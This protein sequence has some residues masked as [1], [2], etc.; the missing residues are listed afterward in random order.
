MIT[1]ATWPNFVEGSWE[2]AHPPAWW[3]FQ[4]FAYVGLLLSAAP[5]YVAYRLDPFLQ[6]HPQLREPM[7][8]LLLLAQIGGLC[9][10]VWRIAR[11][12]GRNA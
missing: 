5:S 4:I 6:A 11:R 7:I 8:A 9:Y 2:L 10:V 12:V 1:L 3:Q